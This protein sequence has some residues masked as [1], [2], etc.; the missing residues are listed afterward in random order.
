MKRTE[1]LF[2]T[3]DRFLSDTLSASE[4]ADFEKELDANPKLQLEV[5][6]HKTLKTVLQEKK[7]V[8]FKKEL[9]TIG[10]EIEEENKKAKRHRYRY[11]GI[12]AAIAVIISVGVLLYTNLNYS[13]PADAL[14]SEYFSPFPVNNEVRSG[15]SKSLEN[16][17]IAYSKKLYD[18]V[19]LQS[20]EI[21]DAV[22]TDEMKI[23]LGNSY[24]LVDQ[25]KKAIAFF[26]EI[27]YKS[28]YYEDAQWYLSLTYLKI[29]D[30]QKAVFYVKNLIEYDGRYRKKAIQL[31]EEM[32]KLK[33]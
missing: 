3:I 28:G 10:K 9:T 14:Y 17:K 19:I 31:L 26:E 24:L 5:A 8:S 29:G 2:D 11:I 32:L 21:S 15:V 6:R 22:F 25:E 23:Y 18:Q 30:L 12:A 4:R 33:N 1:E 7:L 20:S 13:N 27:P 16:I